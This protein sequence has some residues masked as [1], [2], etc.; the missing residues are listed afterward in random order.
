MYTFQWHTVHP[1]ETHSTTRL[2]GAHRLGNTLF[3]SA[4]YLV[5]RSLVLSLLLS[6]SHQCI[7]DRGVSP[8]TIPLWERPEHL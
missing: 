8:G 6:H 7:P 1:R 5:P 3:L 2:Y 4:L